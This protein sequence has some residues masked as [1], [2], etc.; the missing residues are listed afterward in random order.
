MS[1]NF[2]FLVLIAM[3]MAF[4]SPILRGADVPYPGIATSNATDIAVIA[5]GA[6]ATA[7]LGQTKI[8]GGQIWSSGPDGSSNV[9]VLRL[10]TTD[11]RTNTTAQIVGTLAVW[12]PYANSSSDMFAADVN[13]YNNGS[14]PTW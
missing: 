6:P 4:C 5:G 13:Y 11:N 10:G 8:G 9:G 1:S 12:A 14:S 2:S 3:G 7:T